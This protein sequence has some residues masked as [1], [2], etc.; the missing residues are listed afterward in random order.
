MQWAIHQTS[1]HWPSTFFRIS[2]ARSDPQQIRAAQEQIDAERNRIVESHMDTILHTEGMITYRD[3]LEM[4]PND[5][6]IFV[7]QFLNLVEKKNTAAK[8]A[9]GK[10]SVSL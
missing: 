8:A 9:R 1:N 2:V 6:G 4:T 7:Q 3:L 5:I 10:K